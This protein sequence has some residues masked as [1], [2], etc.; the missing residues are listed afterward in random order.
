MSDEKTEKISQTFMGRI[1]N[2][3]DINVLQ[4]EI[5]IMERIKRETEDENVKE[6]MELKVRYVRKRIAA[7]REN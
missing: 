7:L 3:H 2:T 5:G 1:D 6:E 4:S